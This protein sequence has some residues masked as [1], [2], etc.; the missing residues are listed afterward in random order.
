MFPRTCPLC[1]KQALSYEGGYATC[2]SCNNYTKRVTVIKKLLLWADEKAWWWRLPIFVWFVVML[3]QNIHDAGFAIERY[4]NPFSYLDL[5]IHEVGHA[6][7]SF[8]GEFMHI[9]GGSLFQC[10][11]PL[12]WL[13]AFIQKKW[14]F[15][16][17]MCFGWLGLNLFDV[18]TY[19]ADAR[20]R[21]LPLVSPFSFGGDSDSDAVYDSAHDWY[22]LLSRT[23]H[24]NSD[25]IIAHGLRV[26]ATISFLIGFTIG[27]VLL[28]QMMIGS[29]RRFL[30]GK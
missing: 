21:L 9:A 11:F 25:L 15:A 17:S 20:A 13:G 7:F 12:L 5:G 8:F 27:G 28:L 23:N 18:A 4:S 3:F 22:Q 29:G 30:A 10:L 2:D 26:A 1:K 16:A 19:A 6:L 14:Y 24:L